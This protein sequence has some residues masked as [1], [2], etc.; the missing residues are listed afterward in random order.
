M[1]VLPSGNIRIADNEPVCDQ[2]IERFVCEIGRVVEEAQPERREEFRWMASDLL[3]EETHRLS[4]NGR[5]EAKVGAAA[6]PL[7]VL[8]LS[9][10]LLILGVSLVLFLPWIGLMLVD[11]GV[12]G[13]VLGLLYQF[14][15]NQC[16][17]ISTDT[18][19]TSFSSMSRS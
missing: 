19:K 6:R 5:Q 8:A 4:E 14:I 3:G 2:R 10:F 7:N 11:A 16:G 13:I 15:R 12:T 17:N 1:S 9:G 18:S